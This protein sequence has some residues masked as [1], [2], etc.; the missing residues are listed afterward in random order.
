MKYSD[1]TNIL[2][3]LAGMLIIA[4]AII[5]I[6]FYFLNY[7]ALQ[8]ESLKAFIG[9]AVAPFVVTVAIG[10]LLFITPSV[11]T[12]RVISGNSDTDYYNLLFAGLGILGAYLLFRSISDFV[13]LVTLYYLPNDATG[14]I[15]T[16]DRW[17][18]V[19]ATVAEFVFAYI[20]LFRQSLVK[21]LLSKSSR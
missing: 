6:P 7:Y 2:V 19:T 15:F 21:N 1:L 3:R 11:I 17:A 5:N 8:T 18:D 9:I 13:F 4:F 16:L 12:N 10:M 14:G 20:L